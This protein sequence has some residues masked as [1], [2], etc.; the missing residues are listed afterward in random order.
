MYQR[1]IND[2]LERQPNI[3][4]LAFFLGIIIFILTFALHLIQN[5]LFWPVILCYIYIVDL[6]QSNPI[7]KKKI[8][9]SYVC[10]HIQTQYT[11]ARG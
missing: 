5:I 4:T 8:Y 1:R 9:F 3:C 6:F 10:L 7:R 11:Y 2:G